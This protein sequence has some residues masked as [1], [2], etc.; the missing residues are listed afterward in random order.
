MKSTFPIDF[1]A[2]STDALAMNLSSFYLFNS[3]ENLVLI[4]LAL[5]PLLAF[6]FLKGPSLWT[7]LRRSSGPSPVSAQTSLSLDKEQSR[8]HRRLWESKAEQLSLILNCVEAFIFLKD[9]EFKY[10][11]ANQ[12]TA[13]LFGKTPEEMIGLTDFDL[14]PEEEA[15]ILRR[16][17]ETILRTGQKYEDDDIELLKTSE[18]IFSFRTIKTAL[19]S[20][21][22]E[23]FGIC[24]IAADVTLRRKTEDHLQE[25]KKKLEKIASEKSDELDQKTEL[26][27][28]SEERY[29]H[30]IEA[31]SDGI[32]DWDIK[33]GRLYVNSTYAQMLGYSSPTEIS[34]IAADWPQYLH[35]DDAPW[36]FKEAQRQLKDQG[37]YEFE[38]RLRCRDG[39]YKWIL[40]RAKT[41]L[42]DSLGTPLR[43]VGTH[44]DLT[45]RKQLEIELRQAKDAAESSAQLKSLFLANI[46]HEIRTPLNAIIGM[47]HAG[48]KSASD[49]KGRTQ[50]KKILSSGQILLSLVNDVLDFSKMESGKLELEQ[51]PFDLQQLLA[52]LDNLV[53]DLVSSKGLRFSIQIT[54]EVPRR[55]VGDPVRVLQ[56]LLNYVS[57]AIKFT[58]QGSVHLEVSSPSESTDEAFLKFS[59]VDTG[60]G[61]TADQG[62]AL[63]QSFQQGDPSTTRHYGGTGLGLAIAKRLAELMLGEVGFTSEPGLGSTFWFTARLQKDLLQNSPPPHV[64]RQAQKGCPLL[65]ARSPARILLVEDNDINQEVIISYLEDLGAE[66]QTATNGLAALELLE[67][68][69]FDLILMDVQMPVMDGIRTCQIIRSNSD[70]KAIPILALTASAMSGDRERCLTAGMND[71][72]PK[73]IDPDELTR[74]VTS[75]LALDSRP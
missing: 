69:R 22:G 10:Q 30:A 15:R 4:S 53:S 46:S 49:E 28:L 73:P 33:G 36:V 72:V 67:K 8:D 54:S 24:G 38:F 16:Q 11:F 42:K 56:V 27:R 65:A 60:V 12:K 40:S 63:F 37:H 35:P 32:W 2:L 44:V 26:L 20:E 45:P 5:A 7:R 68:R 51:V 39:S 50:L 41:V 1:P 13:D 48:M 64:M 17:D 9:R 29:S 70:W 18:K 75:F 31:A 25:Y 14:L 59:V 3:W 55:L 74:K 52:N 23:I 62:R 66:F 61:I 6:L 58:D 47:A 71:Y 21:S 43:A 19:R 57:N 34:P